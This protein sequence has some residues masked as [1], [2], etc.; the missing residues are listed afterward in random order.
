MKTPCSRTPTLARTAL[1]AALLTACGDAPAVV[2]TDSASGGQ[3]GPVVALSPSV[4]AWVPL[5]LSSAVVVGGA[6]VVVAVVV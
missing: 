4:A 3:T 5:S 2:D 6:V 1:G